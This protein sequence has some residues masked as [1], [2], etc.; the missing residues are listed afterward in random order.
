MTTTAEHRR[1]GEDVPPAVVPPR[2]RPVNQLLVVA[3]LSGLALAQPVLELLGENPTA[4]QFRGLEGSRIA[5]FAAALVVVPPLV[6]WLVGRGVTALH[7]AGA[8]Q[9]THS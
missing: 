5:L 6:L 2:Q 9:S 7:A 1:A 3:G 4:L 8:P